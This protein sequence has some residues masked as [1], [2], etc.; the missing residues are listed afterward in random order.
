MKIED[1]RKII[2]TWYNSFQQVDNEN[3]DL[4]GELREVKIDCTCEKSYIT[5]L[6]GS[7]PIPT[8]KSENLPICPRCKNYPE[9]RISGH[10]AGIFNASTTIIKRMV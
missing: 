7:S 2:E 8:V 5:W 6:N 9:G 10:S 3:L 1:E 4:E